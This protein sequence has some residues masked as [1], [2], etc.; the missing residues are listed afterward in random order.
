MWAVPTLNPPD[1]VHPARNWACLVSQ[2]RKCCFDG[3]FIMAGR[4]FFMSPLCALWRT[5]TV[6]S[7]GCGL[8]LAGV[9]SPSARLEHLTQPKY[10]RERAEVGG[11]R[12]AVRA[13][14]CC[15]VCAASCPHSAPGELSCVCDSSL[16]CGLRRERNQFSVRN[17]CVIRLRSVRRF[18]AERKFNA[19]QRKLNVLYC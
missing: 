14:G 9:V 19:T 12:T 5:G 10:T 15:A 16:A 7:C 17:Q 11:V 2:S 8:G 4:A 3:I 13:R 1:G 18:E 6:R